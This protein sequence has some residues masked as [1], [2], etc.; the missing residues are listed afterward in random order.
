MKKLMIMLGALLAITSCNLTN[1]FLTTT[2]GQLG[3]PKQPSVNIQEGNTTTVENPHVDGA[4]QTDTSETVTL[5]PDETDVDD[6]NPFWYYLIPFGGL[7]IIA[8]LVYRL[9]QQNLKSL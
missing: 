7:G 1:K 4:E 6:G 5:T 8:L 2:D 9:K 3:I